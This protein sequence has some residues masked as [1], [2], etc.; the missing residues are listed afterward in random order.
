MGDQ[1]W[2]RGLKQLYGLEADLALVIF[3]VSD[4]LVVCHL[5]LSS[6]GVT[7]VSDVMSSEFVCE[8]LV[9]AVLTRTLVSGLSGIV[10]VMFLVYDLV[11]VLSAVLSVMFLVY[12]LVSVLS[13]VL[14]VMFLV[15]DLVSVLSAVLSVV[16]DLVSVVSGLLSVV[17][18]VL[19]VMSL[20][21]DLVSVVYQSC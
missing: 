20:V 5:S 14:S 7:T 8:L 9:S 19:S 2:R 11:S 10:L 15:Y 1:V 12:D 4:V 3:L 17:S 18:G 16:Y 21:Y 6:V 13:A